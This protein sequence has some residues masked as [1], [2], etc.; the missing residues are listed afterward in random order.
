VL[1]RTRFRVFLL[2]LSESSVYSDLF[3]RFPPNP[4][5]IRCS[6]GLVF[7]FS[8]LSCPNQVLIRTCFQVFHLILSESSAHLDWSSALA[9]LSCP[10]QVLIRTGVQLFHLI[11]SES[12]AHSDW[13]SALATLSCPNQV[14]IRTGVQ[15]FHLIL[16][17]SSAHSDWSSS[18]PSK[19]VRNR[20]SSIHSIFS[21]LP[22]LI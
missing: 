21:F 10:N 13:S 4:V 18:Y 11:L 8:T 16:S 7:R 1:I 20:C 12:S 5:R 3:S 19:P 6:F 9:T 22:N 2:I 14:F 15:L 17:E